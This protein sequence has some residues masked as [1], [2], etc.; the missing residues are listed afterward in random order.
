MTLGTMI[1]Q[2]LAEA[3]TKALAV[4]GM[5]RSSSGGHAI[6]ADCDDAGCA[7]R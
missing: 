3:P 4:G 2:L 6:Q 7:I 1:G 5:V